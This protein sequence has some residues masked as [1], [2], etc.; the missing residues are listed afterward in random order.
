MQSIFDLTGKTALVTGASSG[1]GWRFAEVLSQAGAK[2]I[3]VARRADRLEELVKGIVA[4][5]GHAKALVMDVASNESVKNTVS[6]LTASDECIDILV[7]DAGI[8]KA[9]PI[10]ELPE[11]NEFENII[12][13][14]LT[15]LW[16]V[17][18]AIANH[19]KE[20]GIEGSIINIAS[21]NGANKLG[22]NF[23]AYCASK[24]A[25]MQ[26]TKALV[27]ELAAHKIRINC[28]VPGLFHTPMTDHRLKDENGRK[29]LEKI[30]PLGFVAKPEDL[31]GTVLLLASNKASRY[32]TGGHF[33]VDGGIS[34]G[35]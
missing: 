31:D 20:K 23:S 4:K 14:N 6:T 21:V 25:V 24:A 2:I 30:I 5:G 18:Q 22:P 11:P 19:M 12:Q 7:N 27:G 26:L 28:I 1:L 17:T 15:G 9:T 10:F 8:A 32:I 29:E 33:T 16:Y 13:T 3:A 35:G 34:W